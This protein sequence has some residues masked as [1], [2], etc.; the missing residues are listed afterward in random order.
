MGIY[1]IPDATWVLK[2]SSYP[3]DMIP[4]AVRLGLMRKP[5]NSDED[6]SLSY[7]KQCDNENRL[8]EV[9]DNTFPFL[10]VYLYVNWFSIERPRA[11]LEDLVLDFR[12]L[13][14]IC[15]NDLYLP[16]LVA[17]IAESSYE[18]YS[19]RLSRAVRLHNE[20]YPIAQECLKKM[21]DAA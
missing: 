9:R 14:L 17:G 2:F 15:Y 20:L 13:P 11:A 16:S 21:L 18:T 1:P 4:D 3:P 8:A 10:F 12:D 5:E 6:Y 19:E 7:N